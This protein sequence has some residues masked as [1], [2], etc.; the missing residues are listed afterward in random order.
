MLLRGDFHIHSCLSPC[1]SLDMSPADIAAEARRRGLSCLALTDHHSARNA[2]AFETACR[3]EGLLPLFGMEIS[4]A[5]EIHCIALFDTPS[6]AL[7]AETALQPYLPDFPNNP[8]R[9]GD[10]PVVD[11]DGEILDFVPRFL[12]TASTL[13]FSK[14]PDFVRAHGGLFYPAHID[15]DAFSVLSQLGH[16]PPETGP[17][18]EAT[19]RGLSAMQT[20]FP[21]RAFVAS[22]DAHFPA[23]IAAAHTLLDLPPGVSFTIASLADALLSSRATPVPHPP[24]GNA[25]PVTD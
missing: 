21:D 20:R 1:A 18:L 6:A 19:R 12:G 7:D 22:S 13:P 16:L 9:F 24:S 25:V 17:I 2:P 3:R 5:E 23:D 15:R 8:D 14:I 10:Q 4:S 11:A